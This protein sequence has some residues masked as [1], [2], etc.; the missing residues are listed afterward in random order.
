[1]RTTCCRAIL[2]FCF[3][4]CQDSAEPRASYDINAN[5]EWGTATAA[6]QVEGGNTHTDWYQWEAS[7]SET[8]ETVAHCESN[9][10]GPNHWELYAEDIALAKAMGHTALRMGLEW[11][12]IEPTQGEYDETVLAHYHAVMDEVLSH[13]MTLLVTLQH[14][15]LPIWVNN[16][17]VPEAGLGG[18]PGAASDA[19]GE[20]PIIE[21]FEGFAR[22]MAEEFGSKVDLWITI[23]EPLVPLVGGYLA[24][25]FPPGKSLQIETLLR[26]AFNMV[27]AH[28]RAYDMLH[29]H[30]Q[31][32]VDGDGQN[33]LVS[34]A[35][36]WRIFD[37]ANPESTGSIE[38]ALRLEYL[39][40]D[41]FMRAIWKGELDLNAD[42]DIDDANEG[43]HSELVGGL[44]WVGVNYYG[45]F[46]VQ[47]SLLR[48]CD[49]MPCAEDEGVE[50]PI[51]FEENPDAT[52]TNDLGWEIY[53]G[54]LVRVLDKVKKYDLPMRITENGIADADDDLRPQ[55]IVAHVQAMQ[56]AMQKGADIRGYYH[57]TLVD[58]FEWAEGYEPRFGLLKVD[59]DDAARTRTKTRGAD[60]LTA[61]I[62]AQ[63]VTPGIVEEFGTFAF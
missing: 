58:N 53:P 46:M 23:N 48:V 25:V 11:G 15:T 30:D 60:A 32:D 39:Y 38:S 41:V 57:W 1:M 49:D 59:Y 35:K 61:L 22:K 6:F 29:A 47:D 13:D 21:A 28:R 10:D 55:F 43:K 8:N 44:D 17:L 50:V 42:G 16:I 56:E 24:G 52:H 18:W 54:G 2:I 3:V 20:S 45:R 7:C 40:N 9:L 51:L 5:F 63:G 33:A 4:S 62:E 14:F 36:H 37:P 34:V 12:K 26:G 19:L 31:G 27:W